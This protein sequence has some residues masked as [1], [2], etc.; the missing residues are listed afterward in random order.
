MRGNYQKEVLYNISFN[1]SEH[2]NQWVKDNRKSECQLVIGWIEFSQIWKD[3][4]FEMGDLIYTIKT[5]IIFYHLFFFRPFCKA[6][7]ATL[8]AS[9]ATSWHP[10]PGSLIYLLALIKAGRTPVVKEINGVIPLSKSAI[11][12]RC[13]LVD[14]W[15]ILDPLWL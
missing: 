7:W 2:I 3:A 10:L 1:R 15:E 5:K 12:F 14:A 9:R 13:A 8:T 4:D 11:I 6:G